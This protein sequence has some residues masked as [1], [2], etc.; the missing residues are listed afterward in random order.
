MSVAVNSQGYAYDTVVGF[1]SW[2]L[3]ATVDVGED[4]V[5]LNT[6]LALENDFLPPEC[7]LGMVQNHFLQPSLGFKP[8]RELCDGVDV[9]SDP[10]LVLPEVDVG[11]LLLDQSLSGCGAGRLGNCIGSVVLQPEP[12]YDI[13]ELDTGGLSPI[14]SNFTEEFSIGSIEDYDYGEVG[15]FEPLGTPSP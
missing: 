5:L 4:Q 13:P 1:T 7:V 3:P 15:V 14:T 12:G 10:F 2:G 11:V 9:C 8:W 6:P